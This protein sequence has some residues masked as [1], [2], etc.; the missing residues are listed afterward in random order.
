MKE[1]YVEVYFPPFP[2]KGR[3]VR[4]FRKLVRDALSP[5]LITLYRVNAIDRND[6]L[7][8]ALMGEAKAVIGGKKVA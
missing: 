7:A 5:N 6:A 8:L 3:K 4:V 1:Y 2:N